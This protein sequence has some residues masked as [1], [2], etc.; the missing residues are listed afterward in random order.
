MAVHLI[1]LA[2]G[3]RIALKNHA[4]AQVTENMGDGI[5]IQVR[6][7]AFPADP[8]LVGSEELCHC[9]DVVRVLEAGERA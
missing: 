9:E 6:Y 4:V 2:P 3:Q 5:W 7:E 1:N 8:S